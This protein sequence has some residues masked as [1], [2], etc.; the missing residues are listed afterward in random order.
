MIPAFHQ[1]HRGLVAWFAVSEW[2]LTRN[3]PESRYV[4]PRREEVVIFAKCWPFTL[5]ITGSTMQWEMVPI[6][7]VRWRRSYH[8]T[9]HGIT[10]YAVERVIRKDRNIWSNVCLRRIHADRIMGCHTEF[11]SNWCHD[12]IIQSITFR[13]FCVL[14]S[15]RPT[16]AQRIYNSQSHPILRFREI[17]MSDPEK[18]RTREQWWSPWVAD[19][20]SLVFNTSETCKRYAQYNAFVSVFIA[21]LVQKNKF[22]P[23]ISHIK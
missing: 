7:F 11:G 10:H 22:H 1:Y 20:C 4:T 3:Q 13:R 9:K 14:S 23:V 5:C 19:S 16:C 17:N 18:T 6:T 8:N 21:N 2:T 15:Y 12:A